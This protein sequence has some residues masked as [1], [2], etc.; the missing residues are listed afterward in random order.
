MS[1]ELLRFE[2]PAAVADW[3]AIDDRVMGGVSHSR[4]RDDR[5]GYAVFEGVVSLEHHGG[6]ASVR[7]RPR[8]FGM[9]PSLNDVLEVC[10]DGKQYTLSVRTDAAFDGVNYQAAF[11]P[12][13][14]IWSVVRLP[15][16]AFLPTFR[17]RP[18]PSA[19]PLDSAR[20][21][22]IGFLIADQPVDAFALAIR[23]IQV[24]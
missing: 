11:A 14:G 16:L 6:F 15:R 18:V 19:P 10:G 12:P 17:G 2:S 23:S 8:D 1:S 13:A 9:P 7:S 24:E 3:Y 20:V 21:R 4:F 22:Q 5:A